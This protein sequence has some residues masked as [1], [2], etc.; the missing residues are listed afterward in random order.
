MVFLGRIGVIE[1][2][3]FFIDFTTIMIQWKVFKK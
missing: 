3:L 2:L 1:V